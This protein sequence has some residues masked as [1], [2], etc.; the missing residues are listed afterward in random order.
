MPKQYTLYLFLQLFTIQL[1]FA[2]HILTPKW[3]KYVEDLTI[4]SQYQKKGEVRYAFQDEANIILV[5]SCFQGWTIN[6]V[7]PDNGKLIWTNSQNQNFPDSTNNIYKLLF[8]NQIDEN[9]TEVIGMKDYGKFPGL[10]FAGF[11][12]RIIYDNK[13]GKELFRSV[14]TLSSKDYVETFGGTLNPII[15]YNKEYRIFDVVP[16]SSSNLQIR[17]FNKDMT[18]IKKLNDFKMT[19]YDNIFGLDHLSTSVSYDNNNIYSFTYLFGGFKDTSSY[20]NIFRK[21]DMNGTITKQKDVS[22]DV[23]YDLEYFA[24]KKVNGGFLVSGYVDTALTLIYKQKSPKWQTVV[25]KFDTLGNKIW[26]AFL[27]DTLNSIY[28]TITTCEDQTRNGYWAFVGKSYNIA[29]KDP[30]LYFIKYD[31][32]FKKIGKVVLKNDSN[33]YESKGI[34][35]ISGGGLI[36]SLQKQSCEAPTS[37]QSEC[38]RVAFLDK[39]QIDMI[40]DVDDSNIQSLNPIELFP[41]P[42]QSEL[43]IKN[44]S[45][46]AVQAQLLDIVGKVIMT[47][48]LEA[49][50]QQNLNTENLANGFYL[51]RCDNGK[52]QWTTKVVKDSK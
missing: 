33:I 7:N 38:H 5:S 40:L 36:L 42:F 16:L 9:K 27:P 48:S 29:K 43:T 22:K 47:F 49:N 26:N 46:E 23:F 41:N 18:Y 25:F 14:K 13:T 35:S 20:R 51:L 15:P 30:E 21:F 31:G 1:A 52:Q 19:I 12:L 39:A 8:A 50:H 4:L 11:L 17:S 2:Q 24:Y 34:W 44:N 32:S 37:D 45:S 10:S 28:Q 6:K 3:V